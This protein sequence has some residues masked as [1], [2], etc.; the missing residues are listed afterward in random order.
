MP[1]R[2]TIS[3]SGTSPSCAF[4]VNDEIRPQEI[5]SLLPVAFSNF[6]ASSSIALLTP[7]VL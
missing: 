6:G 7:T 5:L 4:F 1:P 2:D 3:T